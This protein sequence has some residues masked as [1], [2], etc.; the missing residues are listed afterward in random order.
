M[1]F[2]RTASPEDAATIAAVQGRIYD[3][4]VLPAHW[5]TGA[6]LALMSPVILKDFPPYA[7]KILQDHGSGRPQPGGRTRSLRDD[8]S[9]AAVPDLVAGELALVEKLDRFRR[10]TAYI[11]VEIDHGDLGPARPVQGVW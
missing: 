4:Y 6:G 7:R 10:V 5:S 2:V 9:G 11:E 3:I 8:V 1:V